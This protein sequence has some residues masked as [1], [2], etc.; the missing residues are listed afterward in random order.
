MPGRAAKSG[1]DASASHAVAGCRGS[2]LNRRPPVQTQASPPRLALML[3]LA[4]LA[5]PSRA[6][7]SAPA[8]M[9]ELGMRTVCSCAWISSLDPSTLTVQVNEVVEFGVLGAFYQGA[10]LDW[11]FEGIDAPDDAVTSLGSVAHFRAWNTP[12]TY[13]AT[14]TVGSTDTAP[15]I[16]VVVPETFTHVRALITSDNSYRFGYGNGLAMT[17]QAA[18]NAATAAQIFG[19]ASGAE[20]YEVLVPEHGILY[21][22]AWS[23][24]GVTQGV[25]A[26]FNKYMPGGI[27]SWWSP[28]AKVFSGDPRWEVFAT[29]IDYDGL[30]GPSLELINEQIGLANANAGGPGTSHG[31]VDVDGP[32]CGGWDPDVGI[33]AV[34]EMNDDATPDGDCDNA[35]PKACKLNPQAEWMW[36]DAL[37]GE[38]PFTESTPAVEFL[39]FRLC[40]QELPPAK[41]LDIESDNGRASAAVHP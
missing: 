24:D 5:A 17:P 18:V 36:Y 8:P 20:T 29:G 9:L 35:F 28:G 13:E 1:V 39:I 2:P 31:W 14:A 6:A 33:L 11:T 22:A 15:F 30:P 27:L 16:I 12:G 7:T 4:A 26:Q 10:T 40:V 37:Q 25:L 21:V 38:C 19:C 34:G 41:K 3:L 32:R 23:D